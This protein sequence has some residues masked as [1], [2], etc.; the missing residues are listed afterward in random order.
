MAVVMK[1]TILA[2]KRKATPAAQA[3]ASAMKEAK[4]NRSKY[5]PAPAEERTVDGI[6]FASRVEANRYGYLKI[7]F[8]LG[9]IWDLELQP[10]WNVEI[11]GKPFCRYTA[12]FKYFD[13]KLG[14][15]VIE[16]V[17]TRGTRGEPSYRLRRKAAELAHGIVVTEI[18]L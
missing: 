14:R 16:E 15:L 1:G 17:K 3:Y 13:F 7:R 2:A 4:S 8:R 5:R 6:L 9:E 11:S 12:D 18:V 10:S